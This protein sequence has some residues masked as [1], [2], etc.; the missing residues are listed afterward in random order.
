MNNA[1]I[2]HSGMQARE[3]IHFYLFLF[4]TFTSPEPF[5]Y[6]H[7]SSH[8]LH[9]TPTSLF[10]H[11]HGQEAAFLLFSLSCTHQAYRPISRT[12][13]FRTH[14]QKFFTPTLD[15]FSGFTIMIRLVPSFQ[16]A[17]PFNIHFLQ[18]PFLLSAPK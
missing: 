5:S 13:T 15:S 2:K 4:P 16:Y 11:P 1:V 8:I 10:S 12:K 3:S 14:G 7:I 17:P 6:Q 9:L 18:A